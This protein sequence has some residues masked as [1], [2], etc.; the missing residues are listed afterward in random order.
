MRTSFWKR[1]LIV[2]VMVM[3]LPFTPSGGFGGT[4]VAWA[5]SVY[6]ASSDNG[7]IVLYGDFSGDYLFFDW[8]ISYGNPFDLV[9]NVYRVVDAEEVPLEPGEL[10]YVDN[11]DTGSIGSY[12][13]APGHYRLEMLLLAEGVTGDPEMLVYEFDIPDRQPVTVH[14]FGASGPLQGLMAMDEREEVTAPVSIR[15]IADEAFEYV[16]HVFPDR[17]FSLF[18]DEY[19][20]PNFSIDRGL[21]PTDGDEFVVQVSHSPYLLEIWNFYFTVDEEAGVLRGWLGVSL[22][23]G[24]NYDTVIKIF[25]EDDPDGES[26]EGFFL[27]FTCAMPDKPSHVQVFALDGDEEQPTNVNFR[28]DDVHLDITVKDLDS[29]FGWVEQEIEFRVIGEED[30][31]ALYRLVPGFAPDVRHV[32]PDG[33]GSYTVGPW[34]TQQFD[35]IGP[36]FNFPSNFVYLQLVDKEGNFYANSVILPVVDSMTDEIAMLEYTGMN[37]LSGDFSH[38]NPVFRDDDKSA[39]GRAGTVE[40]QV[41]DYGEYEQLAG[42]DLYYA[43]GDNDILGGVARVY[44]PIAD[45]EVFTHK[46]SNIP[47][48]AKKLAVVPIVYSFGN[49]KFAPTFHVELEDRIAARLDRLYVNGDEV[50][51]KNGSSNYEIIVPLDAIEAAIEVVS[52]GGVV[53][54]DD[55]HVPDGTRTIGLSGD[56]TVV[57]I[58]VDTPDTEWADVY[59]LRILRMRTAEL[60]DDVLFGAI[61]K[62]GDEYEY[63][64]VTQGMTAG[65]LMDQFVK[66]SDVSIEILGGNGQT[67]P[68]DLEVPTGATVRLSRGA[69]FQIITL[70]WLSAHLREELDIGESQPIT[71]VHVVNFVVKKRN[72][73]TGDGHFDKED[74]RVLLKEMD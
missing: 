6:L 47:P 1:S 72:D 35:F 2:L 22:P 21:C 39:G 19:D 70:R 57:T 56:E 54:V 61:V 12:H 40:W 67:V 60:A 58:L 8:E 59:T 5:D 64:Y 51:P 52:E 25:G 14:L 63:R 36:D 20:F 13:W 50:F 71:I 7:S 53:Y 28:L 49:F 15:Q 48:D 10:E 66:D 9:L 44:D 55:E 62:A 4:G 41:P 65:K 18:S 46:L 43:N 32:I 31:F 33:S 69:E 24:F 34:E 73:V 45:P 38:G 11:G 29:R 26:C 37:P 23:D 42:Y 16:F 74:V 3:L 68:N 27:D 30:G 17:C